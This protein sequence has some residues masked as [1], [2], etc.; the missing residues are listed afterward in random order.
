MSELALTPALSPGRG[1]IIG[2][3]LV[4]TTVA[5]VQGFNAGTYSGNSQHSWREISVTQD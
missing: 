1:G 4:A 3:S 5:S 2:R